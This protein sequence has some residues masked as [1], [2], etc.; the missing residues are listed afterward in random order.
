MTPGSMVMKGISSRAVPRKMGRGELF[1][2]LG[3][4]R[5]ELEG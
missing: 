1:A 5:E 4:H 3:R 2:L